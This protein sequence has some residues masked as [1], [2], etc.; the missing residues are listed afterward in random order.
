MNSKEVAEAI[1][2]GEDD[3]EGRAAELRREV[4]EVNAPA[5]ELVRVERRIQERDAARLK[6]EAKRR[7]L[8]IQR[9]MGS[10]AAA[11]EMDDVRV[12]RAAAEYAG[13]IGTLSERFDKLMLLQHEA[14]ALAEAFGLPMPELP[15][16][17]R[18]GARPAVDE[19]RIT[20]AHVAFSEHGYIAE[21][22]EHDVATQ[23]YG[24]RTYRE[25]DTEATA[26]G[27]RLLTRLAAGQQQPVG[28]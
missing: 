12:V 6:A 8:G 7:L 28:K 13:A 19:A 21:H 15:A 9:A 2:E 1:G 11:S 16:I 18:P 24:R 5:E 10:L 22:R 27:H 4:A 14:K 3:L 20:V 17:L 25:L 26:E 23:R